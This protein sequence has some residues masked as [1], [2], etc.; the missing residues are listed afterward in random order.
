MSRPARPTLS[1][2]K[3]RSWILSTQV[4]SKF[5]PSDLVRKAACQFKSWPRIL[6][7]GK[8]NK[9]QKYSPSV[10]SSR[11]SFSCS[12]ALSIVTNEK[13]FLRFKSKA[14]SNEPS[15][16]FQKSKSAQ[17]KKRSRQLRGRIL[18]SKRYN[19]E[20]SILEKPRRTSYRISKTLSFNSRSTSSRWISV[21][22]N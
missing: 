21:S 15:N 14:R 2:I 19:K 12:L 17:T 3:P 5:Y 7:P 4:C 16:L 20:L 22:S 18:W 8:T 1:L 6:R 9:N 11:K 13:A 10:N